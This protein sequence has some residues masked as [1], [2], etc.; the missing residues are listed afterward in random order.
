MIEK[1]NVHRCG[2]HTAI[3]GTIEDSMPNKSNQLVGFS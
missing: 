2:Q 3:L 1:E